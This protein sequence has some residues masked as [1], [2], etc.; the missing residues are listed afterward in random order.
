MLCTALLL[1]L[2]LALGLEPLPA[3]GLAPWL[4]LGLAP[5]LALGLA[6]ELGRLGPGL[7][8]GRLL[9]RLGLSC[10]MVQT[11]NYFKCRLKLNLKGA[12]I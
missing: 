12:G 7:L 10:W 5:W 9:N 2:G 11:K 1:G 6:P 3:L 8:L 4:A